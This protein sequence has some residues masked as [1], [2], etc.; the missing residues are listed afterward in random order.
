MVSETSDKC[1][2]LKSKSKDDLL[3]QELFLLLQRQLVKHFPEY[4][5]GGVFGPVLALILCALRINTVMQ[6]IYTVNK[7]QQQNISKHILS[8]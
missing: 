8:D 4:F 5:D 3:T 7:L 2:N 6:N 1:I